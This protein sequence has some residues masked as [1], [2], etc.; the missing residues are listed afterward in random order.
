[1]GKNSFTMCIKRKKMTISVFLFVV[2]HLTLISDK[3]HW[4]SK[5]EPFHLKCIF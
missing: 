4:L 3:S 5:E 1:M 2:L